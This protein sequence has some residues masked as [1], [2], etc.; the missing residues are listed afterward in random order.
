MTLEIVAGLQL[1]LSRGSW[2]TVLGQIIDCDFLSDLYCTRGMD[3]ENP[4]RV[5]E[6]S[7]S[8]RGAGVV[9]ACYV[10]KDSLSNLVLW[11]KVE[12]IV[13]EDADDF[14]CLAILPLYRFQ[15]WLWNEAALTLL[16]NV[17]REPLQMIPQCV[18]PSHG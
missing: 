15:C 18:D 11:A 13:A 6:V 10:R 9:E 17:S 14:L 4:L 1:V 8:V 5:I 3:V 2:G 12:S 16:H 7:L